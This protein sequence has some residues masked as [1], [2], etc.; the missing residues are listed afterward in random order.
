MVMDGIIRN[1]DMACLGHPPVVMD[2]PPVGFPTPPHHLRI[3]WLTHAQHVPQAGKI[4]PL[5]HLLARSPSTCGTPW[6]RCTRC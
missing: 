2:A 1:Q 4:E 6:E 3:Q 5:R